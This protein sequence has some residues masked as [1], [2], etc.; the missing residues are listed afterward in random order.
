MS[1]NVNLGY[2][3]KEDWSEFIEMI[4][5][6]ERMHDTW[7]EWHKDFLKMFKKLRK[8]G[9]KVRKVIVHLDKLEL[10]CTKREIPIDGSARSR[11][12]QQLR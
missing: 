2:Y 5:D 10:Y 4:D 9:F 11:F 8:N 1:Q 3:Q 7:E 6:R 12:I